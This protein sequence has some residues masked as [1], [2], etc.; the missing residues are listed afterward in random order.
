MVRE[1]S[2]NP[3][4]AAADRRSSLLHML[5]RGKNLEFLKLKVTISQEDELLFLIDT[6]ADIS[7]I[8]GN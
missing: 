2:C 1:T 3:R 5:H 4:R 8:K 6:R 7:L